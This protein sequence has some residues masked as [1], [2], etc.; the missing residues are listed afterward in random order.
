[1]KLPWKPLKVEGGYFLMADISACKDLIPKRYLANHSY[2]DPSKSNQP[3]VMAYELN[4]PDGR[5]PLDLAFCRW[6][7]CENGVCMM[8]N[9]FFYQSTSP[10]ICDKFVRLA[11]CKDPVDTRVTG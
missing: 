2:E 11:I 8:P 5:V 1:M 10:Y 7:A 9:S 4:M 3:P 6:M